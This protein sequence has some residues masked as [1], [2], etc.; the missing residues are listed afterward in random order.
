MSEIDEPVIYAIHRV[1][2]GGVLGLFF[3]P[4][5]VAPPRMFWLQARGTSR[6][7]SASAGKVGSCA[8]CGSLKAAPS[9]AAG[10]RSP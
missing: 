9:D 3:G 1:L 7:G 5:S 4:P 6:V 8:D 2:M 10:E